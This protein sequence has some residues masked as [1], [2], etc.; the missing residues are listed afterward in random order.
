[1]RGQWAAASRNRSACDSA[2]DGRRVPPPWPGFLN[3]RS[4][5]LSCVG[6]RQAS[7]AKDGQQRQSL[8][9]LATGRQIRYRQQAEA[10]SGRQS[11]Q[12]IDR[13]GKTAGR[14]VVI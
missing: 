11:W 4:G 1:M 7:L 8:A 5:Q 2:P 3:G 9:G 6:N 14:D 13:L 10:K 12:W